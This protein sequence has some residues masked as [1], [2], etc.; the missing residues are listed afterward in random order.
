MTAVGHHRSRS[1]QART[2]RCSR[3]RHRLG[4]H[5]RSTPEGVTR[6]GDRFARITAIAPRARSRVCI[7]CDAH[8]L[9][10]DRSVRTGPSVRKTCEHPLCDGAR[11]SSLRTRAAT[12]SATRDHVRDGAAAGT[13]RR[14]AV[15]LAGTTEGREWAAGLRPIPVTGSVV[16]ACTSAARDRS[17]GPAQGVELAASRAPPVYRCARLTTAGVRPSTRAIAASWAKNAP[18]AS[19]VCRGSSTCGTCPHSSS[20]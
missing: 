11:Q 12:W 10:R 14:F 13:A 4:W 5:Y 16:C 9:G 18:T 8:G 7:R 6:P 2:R 20:R 19:W 1:G 15:V 17:T 3:C